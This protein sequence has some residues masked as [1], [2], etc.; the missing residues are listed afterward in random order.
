MVGRAKLENGKVSPL[1]VFR[2]QTERPV[3]W[4]KAEAEAQK[5]A[6]HPAGLQSEK[7]PASAKGSSR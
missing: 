6:D 7:D 3:D 5:L 2:D 1:E 4:F